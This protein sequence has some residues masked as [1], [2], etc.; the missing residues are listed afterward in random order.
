MGPR[1]LINTQQLLPL[2]SRAVHPK[3]QTKIDE[4]P[5]KLKHRKEAYRGWKQG[6]VTWEVKGKTQLELNMTRDNKQS[7]NNKK[8][9]C[10]YT[11]N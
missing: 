1:K 2:S 11:G 4:L 6:C 8:D 9:F 5:A 10:K 7:G 3:G